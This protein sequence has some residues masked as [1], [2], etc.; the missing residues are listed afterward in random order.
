[1]LVGQIRALGEVFGHVVKLPLLLI[2][3][4]NS[5]EIPRH[6]VCMQS[7]CLPNLGPDRP[8]AKHLIPHLLTE[9]LGF[10]LAQLILLSKALR[11]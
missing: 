7:Q 6:T 5:V 2:K 4:N 1:M 10:T 9:C 3:R 8:V 11:C